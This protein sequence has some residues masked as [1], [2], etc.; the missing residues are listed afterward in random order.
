LS[1]PT[2][3]EIMSKSSMGIHPTLLEL[4]NN[5]QF[6]VSW[7]NSLTKIKDM[8]LLVTLVTLLLNTVANMHA[9][10]EIIQKGE[11]KILQET[12]TSAIIIKYNKN[13]YK[14]NILVNTCIIQYQVTF[15]W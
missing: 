12:M 11:I 14:F 1:D 9:R 7:M 13:C 4:V 15:I 5:D 6:E 2:L 10:Q 8:I 3:V